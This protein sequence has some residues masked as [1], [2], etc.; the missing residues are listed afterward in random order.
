MKTEA[1]TARDHFQ[2]FVQETKR[3]IV[4]ALVQDQALDD[5]LS[6]YNVQLDG[7]RTALTIKDQVILDADT[8]VESRTGRWMDKFPF[9]AKKKKLK[10]A[11]KELE[12]IQEKK[13]LVER[14]KTTGNECAN[15]LRAIRDV[16]QRAAD[17]VDSMIKGFDSIASNMQIIKDTIDENIRE[18]DQLVADIEISMVLS[19][20]KELGNR[21]ERY[22]MG[23][24]MTPKT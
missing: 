2:A 10:V 3:D 22:L 1:E 18:A 13:K 7:L 12:E 11:I 19:M 5:L 4:N 14:M 21:A 24:Y 20:W 8:P 23:A 6:D 16:A 17:A 9:S 15:H